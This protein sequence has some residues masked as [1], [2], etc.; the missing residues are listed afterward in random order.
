MERNFFQEILYRLRRPWNTAF[1]GYFILI[2]IV[3][4]GFGVPYSF[5]TAINSPEDD[6]IIVAQNMA[7]YFMAVLASSVVDLNLS[8]G[9]ENRVSFLVYSFLIFIGGFIILL[10]TY[11]VHTDW[12]FIPAALG[13][14]ICWI[15]WVLA[16]SDNE[17]LSDENFFYNAMRGKGNH[18]ENW[19]KQ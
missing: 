19:D 12:A 18:G 4:G 8:W 2:V 17:K 10:W 6:G 1:S 9:I 14:L 16:N 7:T 13:C 11:S 5:F 3:F 15:V